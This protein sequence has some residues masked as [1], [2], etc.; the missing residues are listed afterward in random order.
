M[1]LK[2]LLAHNYYQQSGGEDTVFT[3]EAALLRERGHTVIEYIEDNHRILTMKKVD[4][5]IQTLWSQDSYLKI[6]ELIA[7]GKPDIVH[8]HNTFPLISPSAYYACQNAG[9]PAIQSLDNPRLLCPSATFFRDGHLCQDCMNKTPP[10]PSVLHACYHDSRLQTGVIASMLTLHRWLGTW[11]KKINFYLVATEFYRRKFI[12]G[13]LPEEKVIL[14]PHFVALDPGLEKNQRIGDYAIFMA[15][16]DP[17]KGVRTMLQA[18]RE[19]SAIPLQIRGAGQLEQEVRDFIRTNGMH[20]IELVGRMTEK[21]LDQFMRQASF[22]VWPSEGY[23]E[24]F[25]MVA[26]ECFAVGIPVIASK[27]GVMNEIVTDG[28]T[29]L[30]FTPG[31][32][33]DLARKVR[34]AWEHPHEMAEMGGNAR[35]EYE[36]K[37]TAEKNYTMLMEIYQRAIATK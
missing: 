37:Y 9:V 30:L 32:P 23:Y 20:N 3:A 10:W 25:G 16:L 5:A 1:T 34:W 22:L 19:L 7:A 8:F 36:E 18:W 35:R 21:E 2:I 31:D 33:A 13:G 6:S 12:E 26:V 4:V 14:K 27:I 11:E 24:T 17:E 28:V 15:R 29:G